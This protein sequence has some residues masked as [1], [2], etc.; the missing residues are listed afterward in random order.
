LTSFTLTILRALD[1]PERAAKLGLTSE[2][3]ACAHVLLPLLEMN[4]VQNHL[5]FHTFIKPFLY[6]LSADSPYIANSKWS[7]PLECFLALY[8]LLTGGIFK[9]VQVVTQIFAQLHYHIRATTL[10]HGLLI[11][12]EPD[13]LK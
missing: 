10:Y 7:D 2:H 1:E 3:L 5:A 11:N 4:N 13:P 12:P 9:K 8:C 6:P